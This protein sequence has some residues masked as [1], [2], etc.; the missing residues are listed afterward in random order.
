[1]EQN[2]YQ[3]YRNEGA[4]QEA[5]D[6]A[7]QLYPDLASKQSIVDKYKAQGYKAADAL[8]LANREILFGA[9][10]A[11]SYGE[12]NMTK[13]FPD[14]TQ[15]YDPDSDFRLQQKLYEMQ[16]GG[17][18]VRYREGTP[19]NPM[20]VTYQMRL[21]PEGYAYAVA[22]KYGINL[23]GSGQKITIVV[24]DS[25]GMGTYGKSGEA[26]P[27]VIVLGK[28]A[29]IDEITLAN[30]IAHELSHCRDFIRGAGLSNQQLHK[31]HGQVDSL[32]S[33]GGERTVYGAGNALEAYIR[34]E[35]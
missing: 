13:A 18:E 11:K 1:M 19:V 23:R 3:R 31:P 6:L 14:A 9:E 12:Q 4:H 20:E 34:G 30:T 25:L 24:D 32:N 27:T 10:A 26:Y 7:G 33:P 22:E 16:N 8:E 21:N 35:R 17:D 15:P 5:I 29:F 2:P 28:A